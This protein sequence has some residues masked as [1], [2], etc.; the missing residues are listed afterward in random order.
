V[1]AL[2]HVAVNGERAGPYSEADL[3]AMISSGRVNAATQVWTDGMDD[4]QPVSSIPRL[5]AGHPW[6]AGHGAAPVATTSG[7]AVASLVC[8]VTSLVLILF[9]CGAVSGLA[10]LPAVITGH[11]AI[12]AIGRSEV[13]MA[14]R[15]LAIAGLVT[16][17]LGLLAQLAVIAFFAFAIWSSAG[18]GP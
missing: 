7:L 17:Y 15:G 10:G 1:S 6:L 14:G 2:W 13:P 16:G 12:G 18:V 11:M 3:R 4:W 5:C 8:G 9:A